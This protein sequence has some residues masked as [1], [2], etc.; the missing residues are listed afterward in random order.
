MKIRIKQKLYV[1]LLAVLSCVS[2]SQGSSSITYNFSVLFLAKTCDV[3]VEN[4][5]A[6]ENLPG[7]GIVTNSSIINDTATADVKLSLKNCTSPDIT[8][9]K[10]YISQGNT[11]TGTMDFF[12][13]NP[14]GIIGLQL[15]DGNFVF[16]KTATVLPEDKSVVWRNI[17]S[18][19]E[20][21]TIK[22]RLRCKTAGCKPQ[23]GNFSASVTFNYYID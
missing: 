21:K 14:A 10:V 18:V 2:S 9:S 12:N 15:T 20:T 3:S 19:A 16:S 6:I 13:D 4:E 7:T 22:A 1:M 23:E 5:I 17:A 8:G 11:L